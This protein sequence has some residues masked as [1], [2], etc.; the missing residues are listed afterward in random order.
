[1]RAAAAAMRLGRLS[2]RPYLATLAAACLGLALPP[3]D[4]PAQ[5]EWPRFRGVNGTGIAAKANP[6]V[7]WDDSTNIQ[8][9]TALPGPGSSSPIVW[10]NRVFV[11]SYSGYGVSRPETGQ[12]SELKRHVVCLDLETGKALWDRAVPGVPEEDSSS[13]NIMEHG[14][15]SNTPATD[16]K[17]IYAFLGKSGVF[18]FDMDGNQVWQTSVGT[19]SGSRRWGS[20]GGV[21]LYKNLVIVNASDES[22]SIRALDAETGKEVWQVKSDRLDSAYGTPILHEMPDGRTELLI[23][24]PDNLWGFDPDT[25]KNLWYCGTELGG[26]VVPGV[27]VGRDLAYVFGG[28]PNTGSVAV[29]LGGTGN[30]TETH[31]AWRGEGGSYVP[32]PVYHDGRLHWVDDN[33]IAYSMDASTGKLHY[34][35]RVA[36]PG[37][38]KP[39]YA[40][41]VLA[42]DRIY[43]VS[44]T[45]GTFVIRAKPEHELIATNKIASDSSQFNATPAIVGDRL[46]LRSDK[47]IYC[48][49]AA[50]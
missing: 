47:F 11:T 31:L 32:T 3:A 27:V 19:Q 48:I 6:P 15:A 7:T 42:G 12:K 45:A 33:G 22:R 26:N 44:R 8:W 24:V 36:P 10:R 41:P 2:V 14:Y 13:G 39:F 25:G 46:I 23:A 20:S 43:A 50:R 1:M 28:F 5:N 40:S 18:A 37:R 17:R 34:R 30:V 49:A 4:E 29:R 9:K 21:L 16:G 35:Q 38:G